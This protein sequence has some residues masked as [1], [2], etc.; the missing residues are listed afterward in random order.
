MK[1]TWT[2]KEFVRV[3]GT[4]LAAPFLWR[5]ERAWAQGQ[6]IA[7]KLGHPDT[8]LHPNQAI[9]LKFSELVADKTHGAVKIQVF[10]GGQLGSETNLISGMQT[11]IVDM[12]MHTTGF[13]ESFYPKIQVLDL[14]F[15]FKDA[16]SAEKLLDGE[17]GQN[18]L[19]D[20]PSKG[21]YGFIW[22]HY[23]W[24]V[25][26]TASQPV[27]VPA[28]LKGLKI[29]IQPGAA[30]AASFK[31]LGAVP[32]VMDISEVYLGISQKTIAGL[33]VPII[34]VVSSK[35]YEVVK[36][37]ALTNHVYN[38]GALMA[39]KR[40][41]DSLDPAFQKAIRDAAAEI[42]PVWRKAVAD[43][44]KEDQA[45]LQSKGL[46]I[47]DIDYPAFRAA[48]DPVY[49]EFRDKIGADLVARVLKAG[50]G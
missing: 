28:D 50:Q 44:S 48:M 45:F 19:A 39:S 17:I 49:A 27:H 15:I 30:F 10:A 20:M 18:L 22:G 29:R 40:K 46:T 12:A 25:T 34:A 6:P 37:V 4:A 9:A 14:P 2:R 5:A 16:A 33:E 3:A 26:E 43:K 13:L 8:T 11:G 38:A 32:V 47:T 41:F 1:R 21:I 31:A 23:A 24:R 35:L 42:Q 7:L 36:C